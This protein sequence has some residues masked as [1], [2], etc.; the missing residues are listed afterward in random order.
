[1]AGA[2][3]GSAFPDV[4][5]AATLQEYVGT[6]HIVKYLAYATRQAER[7]SSAAV[8]NLSRAAGVAREKL[9]SLTVS[10]TSAR[11]V[12]QRAIVVELLRT[13]AAGKHTGS[14][15][16]DIAEQALHSAPAFSD[17]FLIRGRR[18]CASAVCASPGGHDAT[19]LQNQRLYDYLGQA[20]SL[21]EAG[22][23]RE[24]Y[25]LRPTLAEVL[26]HLSP[27]DYHAAP[28][29]LRLAYARWFASLGLQYSS[30]MSRASHVTRERH[31]DPSCHHGGRPS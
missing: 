12:Q 6:Y 27:A 7:L 8:P 11:N 24:G 1:M 31:T 10:R 16:R 23:E 19:V 28:G 18:G 13:I 2:S 30:D 22:R 17:T 9:D 21:G 15:L 29:P 20:A 25:S 14:E 3:S 4:I 26:P 5:G